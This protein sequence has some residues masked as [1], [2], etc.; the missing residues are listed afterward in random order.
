[1]TEQPQNQ[2]LSATEAKSF[3]ARLGH[4]REQFEADLFAW[5]DEQA[6][7]LVSQTPEA[8]E[9][10]DA[11]R[12]LLASGG[13]RLR[14]ALVDC[15]YRAASVTSE[16]DASALALARASELLHA[17]LLIHD[18]IMDRAERRRDQPTAHRTFRE[19][20]QRESWMGSSRHYGDSC[21]ILAGDLASSWA[22]KSLFDAL[23]RLP[24]DRAQDVHNRFHRMMDEVIAGQHLEMRV[25]AQRSA[26]DEELERILHLKSGA[27]SV[28]RPLELGAALAGANRPT[29]ETLGRIGRNLGEAF[30][31]RDDLL[32]VF[33]DPESTGK[34]VGGD[35]LEGK[36][37]CVIQGALK[38]ASPEDRNRIR[39]GLGQPLA[40]P[41]LQ[42]LVEILQKNGARDHASR[43]ITERVQRAQRVI[44]FSDLPEETK[45]WL[46]G[47]GSSLDTEGGIAPAKMPQAQ[48]PE[49]HESTADR[50]A[51]H[52]K[53]A[54]QGHHQVP[55]AAF[56][57]YTFEH[58][59]LP[60]LAEE[61][62]DTRWEFLGRSLNAPILISCMTGGTKPAGVIN[63]HLAEA[64]EATRVGLGVGSQRAAI[65]DSSQA[66]TFRV[67]PYAPSIPLLANLGAVQ[68]NYGYSLDHCKRAVDMIEADALVLHM[69]V[70]QE[71]VQPEGQT[72]FRDLLPKIE[73]IVDGLPVPVIAKEVG[74]GISEGTARKLK[75]AG[76]RILDVAGSG[77]TSWAKIEASRAKEPTVGDRFA[78]WGIETPESI[79][80]VSRVEGLQII[81]SGGIRSGLD[82][83]KA[84]ALGADLA[85]AAYP[86]LEP[87]LESAEAV[88]GRIGQMRQELRIC[89]TCT[90]SRSIADLKNRKLSRKAL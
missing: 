72:N 58:E 27:Y 44:A 35:I 21:G 7:F 20:H 61:D 23:L 31:L 67:R 26:T 47:L 25:A 77:G 41:E 10:V 16:S 55:R 18:D 2:A 34:P 40:A 19:L 64:A 86:F 84:L 29:M 37:T 69:N 11:L 70:L 30:Q 46:A 42:E 36:I 56:D 5:F 6:T 14:P 75:D 81:G 82:V 76:V 83:G 88:V 33:G 50:K 22:T 60:E 59:A 48:R 28:Q 39:N 52:I 74:A 24:G 1:M 89:M 79:E 85:A 65:E 62:I 8:T 53:L 13:K 90:G 57:L 3:G 80:A 17:Y 51:D 71:W 87:A 68:L 4:F 45:T 15:G 66:S 49:G 43:L 78:D 38:H 32:G 63:R 9:L 12:R 73:A 54:L